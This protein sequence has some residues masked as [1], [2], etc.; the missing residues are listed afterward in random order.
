[1]SVTLSNQRAA[2]GAFSLSATMLQIMTWASR[3]VGYLCGR[4]LGIA[5][6]LMLVQQDYRFR[7]RFRTICTSEP[8]L[9]I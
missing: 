4:A 8:K 9:G 5:D 6:L 3:F 1:M 2:D 7:N